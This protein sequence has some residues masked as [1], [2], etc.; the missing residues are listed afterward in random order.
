MTDYLHLNVL[1]LGRLSN[2]R[3]QCGF[4]HVVQRKL[5]LLATVHHKGEKNAL[6]KHEIDLVKA[7]ARGCANRQK[8]A[9]NSKRLTSCW[10]SVMAPR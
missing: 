3:S 8:C 4:N 7:A 2:A 9:L 1:R 5:R 10:T 6:T